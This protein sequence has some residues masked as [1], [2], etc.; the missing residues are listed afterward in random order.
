MTAWLLKLHRWV[1]IVFALPLIFVLGTGLILS[2]EPWL[3]TR[4]IE[5]GRV[6]AERIAALLAKH[7]GKGEARAIVHRSYD[8]TLTIGGGRGGGGV[9]ADVVSGEA[10]PGIS[11][12]A[13]LLGTSR[14]MHETLL[15]DA[16]W[17][18][19]ASTVAML[20]L[21]A[22][23]VAMGLPRWSNTL[24]GWHKSVAWGLLPLV[25][26]SPL[27]GLFIA[28]GITFI[29]APPAP[30]IT[31]PPVAQ[32]QPAK[33]MPLLDAVRI[34]GKSHDLSGLVWIRT[35][36]GNLMV[37]VVEGGEYR[38]FR[39]TREGT[40]AM[41]RNWPRLWHEGIFAGGWSALLNVITSFA[42]IGLLATGLTMWARATLRRRRRVAGRAMA[43]A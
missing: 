33:P 8:R 11:A 29:P 15:L 5:P 2:F 27:T 9:V 3:V 21:P 31:G 28:T 32:Q 20:V 25:V 12:M 41:P 36:G 24:S 34:V 17:L 7:D 35:Q 19:V 37:R 40:T 43:T 6:T 39:V 26:L 42:L 4:A 14:G 16:T 30:P 13:N 10:R 1:A 22:L 18:V 23:G 38:T